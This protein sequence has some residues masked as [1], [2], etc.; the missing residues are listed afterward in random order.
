MEKRTFFE[1]SGN[2]FSLKCKIKIANVTK[3]GNGPVM[4]YQLLT[5][6]DQTPPDIQRARLNETRIVSASNWASW[7]AAF[8]TKINP[9]DRNSEGY[10]RLQNQPAIQFQ[11]DGQKIKFKHIAP[12]QDGFY[13]CIYRA[14][15]EK[16]YKI[17][18]RV[19]PCFKRSFVILI[20]FRDYVQGQRT[21]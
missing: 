13:T 8:G 3:V 19:I 2:E 18:G 11:Q 20:I 6:E 17:I 4:W 5:K 21:G 7:A 15:C 16:Q 1:P 12:T 9:T 14:V 10:R